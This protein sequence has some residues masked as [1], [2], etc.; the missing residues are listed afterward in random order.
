V[1]YESNRRSLYLPVIRAKLFDFFQTFDFPDPGVTVGKRISTT[2]APQALYLMN[3]AFAREQGYRL[4]NLAIAGSP[5]T[6]KRI[7]FA[8]R[9]AFCRDATP[10]EVSRVTEF[11]ARAEKAV[12]PTV[13]DPGKR[14]EKGVGGLRPDAL[15]E[16]RVPVRGVR[17]EPPD[18]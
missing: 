5:E 6:P 17:F 16:Q 14:T 15:R 2:V 3:S 13:K 18:H 7:A 1:K 9:R 4:A 8:Y 12:E 11:L 10:D